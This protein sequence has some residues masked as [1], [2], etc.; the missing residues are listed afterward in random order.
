VVVHG[1][2]YTIP[3]KGVQW[4]VE[5][6]ERGV[7]LLRTLIPETFTQGDPVAFRDILFRI[8]VLEVSGREARPEEDGE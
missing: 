3:Y 4:E 7:A 2:F 8:A 5:E 6:W 1:G